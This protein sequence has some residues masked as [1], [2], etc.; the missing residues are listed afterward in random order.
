[1]FT[2]LY[3]STT[4]YVQRRRCVY[5]PNACH[6][7]QYILD[8]QHL[9]VEIN[10]VEQTRSTFIFILE[11]GMMEAVKGKNMFRFRRQEIWGTKLKPQENNCV[12]EFNTE[13]M[14]Q[15]FSLN[16]QWKYRPYT[17]QVNIY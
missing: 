5:I 11:A 9:S 6:S 17:S 10:W 12:T 16:I 15:L 7:A 14:A 13:D 1:M 8:A 4:L 3:Y 2:C